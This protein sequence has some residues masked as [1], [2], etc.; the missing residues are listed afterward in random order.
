M[1]RALLAIFLLSLAVI[2]GHALTPA[3]TMIDAPVVMSYGGLDYMAN[4]SITIAQI[5]GANLSMSARI[6]GLAGKSVSAVIT[7]T[8][9]GNGPDSYQLSA[10]S[11]RGWIVKIVDYA[12]VLAMN[13]SRLVALEVQIPQDAAGLTDI[14]TVRASSL[15]DGNMATDSLEVSANSR[16]Q[17]KGKKNS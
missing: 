3:G 17:G 10:T 7:L 2:S 12:G 8:N 9:A 13:E 14:I 4:V 1:K 5:G 6:Q 11:A 15:F 16:G